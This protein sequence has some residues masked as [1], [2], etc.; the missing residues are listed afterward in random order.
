[1]TKEK[2]RNNLLNA[3]TALGLSI[4]ICTSNI[5]SAAA[6]D[7]FLKIDSVQGASTNVSRAKWIEGKIVNGKLILKDILGKTKQAN[8]GTYHLHDG[9]VVVVSSGNVISIK[10]GLSSSAQVPKNTKPM[11]TSVKPSH[12]LK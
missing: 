6:F 8:Q 7:N 9:S 11:T 5:T 1:M 3:A 10:K 4:G 12:V 2:N